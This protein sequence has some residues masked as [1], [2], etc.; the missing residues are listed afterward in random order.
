M[1]L[2]QVS[3]SPHVHTEESVKKIMWT[4]IIALVP[5]MIFSFLFFGLQAIVLTLVAVVSCVFFEWIIQKYLLKITPTI[6]DGS[7][8]ITGILLAFNLPSNLPWWIVIIGALVA[9]GLGKMVYGGLGNNLFNPALVGRVFLLISFPVQMT[10]WPR[11]HLLFSAPLAADATTGAT[12]LGMIK[13][14]L[15]Q[16]KDASE[17]MNALPTY[18]QMLLGDRGGSLGEVAALAIIA[19]GIFMLIRKVISWHIPVT[20][21]GSAFIFAAIL[22]LINPGL[23]IP[24]SYHILCGGLL[25]G[26]I[27][28][29]T[30]MVTSPMSNWGKIVFGIGCGLLTIIIRVAGSYPEGVSFAILIMNAFVP[31]INKGFKPKRFGSQKIKA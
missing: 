11:P 18:A 31:L 13:M 27:F 25:L 15:T 21:I 1:A 8:I 19:G 24:P 28:M 4:V 9:I 14:T 12:P 26:A 6:T 5:T 29:A 16:G 23:Y 2:L 10:T 22:H 30:D 17:L 3:G 7:A 20:F